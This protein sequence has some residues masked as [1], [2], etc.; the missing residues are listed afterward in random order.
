MKIRQ[1]NKKALLLLLRQILCLANAY[2]ERAF[3]PTFKV[4]S[5]MHTSTKAVTTKCTEIKLKTWLHHLHHNSNTHS[6][7][8]YQSAVSK[9]ICTRRKKATVTM[10]RSPTQTKLSSSLLNCA[11]Y[12]CHV[13][14]QAESS[15]DTVQWRRNSC[16]WDAFVF[17][18]WH[19]RQDISQSQWSYFETQCR[20]LDNSKVKADNHFTIPQT[21][22]GWIDLGIV[23][24]VCIRMEER[25]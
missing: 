2:R 14:R 5:R 4:P 17:L 25:H 18:L 19:M 24:R 13:M 10:R 21:A 9:N 8:I 7:A 6:E 11:R 22:E 12:L 1:E 16:L 15:R 3:S 23:V 20:I